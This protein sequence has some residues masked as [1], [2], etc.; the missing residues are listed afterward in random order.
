MSYFEESALVIQKQVKW[1]IF[2]H[3]NQKNVN[4]S[5]QNCIIHDYFVLIHT[6]FKVP[7]VIFLII[8]PKYAESLSYFPKGL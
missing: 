4:I 2:G 7:R 3:E 5:Y 6:N 8:D 1:V